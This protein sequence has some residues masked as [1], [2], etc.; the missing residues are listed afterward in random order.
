MI[1]PI[2]SEITNSV[3]SEILIKNVILYLH[4]TFTEHH[5]LNSCIDL[6]RVQIRRVS[7][8]QPP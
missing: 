6:W 7:V 1:Y 5:G 2:Y 8:L 4:L 3:V